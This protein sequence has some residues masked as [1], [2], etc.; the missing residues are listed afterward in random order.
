MNDVTVGPELDALV[1]EKVMGWRPTVISGASLAE[2]RKAWFI[3]SRTQ[4]TE[5]LWSET[6][7]IPPPY[8]TTWEGAGLVV[9]R[10]Q[11]LGYAYMILDR[12]EGLPAAGFSQSKP[13]RTWNAPLAGAIPI[14]ITPL[15]APTVEEAIC[16]AALA[17]VE[18]RDA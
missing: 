1:A 9:E 17:A 16:R 8:S 15:D 18:N 12:G 4:D 6:K 2:D 13:V 5:T 10:M 11:E 7:G 3:P 14:E